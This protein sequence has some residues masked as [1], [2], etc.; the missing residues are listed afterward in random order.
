[1]LARSK[2]FVWQLFEFCPWGFIVL[3]RIRARKCLNL[4]EFL[5]FIILEER[6]FALDQGS[7]I[8]DEANIRV[9]E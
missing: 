1:M 5:V 6:Y 8:E 4:Y 3:E 7:Q 2:S 9:I